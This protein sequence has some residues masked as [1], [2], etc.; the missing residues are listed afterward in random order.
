MVYYGL[1]PHWSKGFLPRGNSGD[2]RLKTSSSFDA[3]ET[4]CFYMYCRQWPQCRAD[5][6]PIP[7]TGYKGGQ[8][9][10]DVWVDKWHKARPTTLWLFP[11]PAHLDHPEA[12]VFFLNQMFP[13]ESWLLFFSCS[14]SSPKSNVLQFWS[15]NKRKIL[16]LRCCGEAHSG[17]ENTECADTRRL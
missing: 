3:H 10:Q 5:G 2:R 7:G 13:R 9:W 8:M 1:K 14:L 16:P 15:R 6:R 17:T 12:A 11:S 4:Q